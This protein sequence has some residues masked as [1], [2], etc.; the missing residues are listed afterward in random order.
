V[1]SPKLLVCDEPVSALDVSVQAQVINLLKE[2]G[3]ELNLA[4]LFISHD[5]QVVRH[6]SDRVAVMYFG[7]IVEAA[8]VEILF[9]NPRHPY[10]EE[11]LA[12]AD[13]SK[14][15]TKA[16]QSV[17]QSEPLS[18]L[19][20]PGGCP[21]HPRCPKAKPDCSVSPPEARFLGEDHFLRC[22]L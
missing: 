14:I 17:L 5:L 9:S 21:Y 15:S 6:V 3:A 8:P 11:L 10:T 19:A 18:P 7:K 13:S 20:P 4:Q 2:T 16:G 12:A 22:I 1:L